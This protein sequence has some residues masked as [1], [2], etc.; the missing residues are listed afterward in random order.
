MTS[1]NAKISIIVFS[2][3]ASSSLRWGV[4][5][6]LHTICLPVH[7]L[8]CLARDRIWRTRGWGEIAFAVMRFWLNVSTLEWKKEGGGPTCK[9]HGLEKSVIKLYLKLG[10]ID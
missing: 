10:R 8:C 9:F 1:I 4:H 7:K 6:S 2:F 5:F 3:G